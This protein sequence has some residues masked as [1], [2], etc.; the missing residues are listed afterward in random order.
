MVHNRTKDK[1]E[2][3]KLLDE[4]ANWLDSPAGMQRSTLDR[5]G[6][7]NDRTIQ[8]LVV[9]KF[10]NGAVGLSDTHCRV[11]SAVQRGVLY[12]D[13]RQGIGVGIQQLLGRQA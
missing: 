7:N 13:S 4:G 11:G 9:C 8:L 3:A 2:V 12:A 6:G 5:Y 1:A 10:S